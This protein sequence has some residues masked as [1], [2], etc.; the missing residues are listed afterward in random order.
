MK[1]GIKIIINRKTYM[2]FLFAKT[3]QKKRVDLKIRR[4]TANKKTGFL[5]NKTANDIFT[6]VK[7]TAKKLPMPPLFQDIF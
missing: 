7:K 6:D 2:F 1:K 4:K 5:Q 3:G